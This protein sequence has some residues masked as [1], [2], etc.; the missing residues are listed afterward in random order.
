MIQPALAP[1]QI[2]ALSF[3]DGLSQSPSPDNPGLSYS[4]SSTESSSGDR[5]IQM[6]TFIDEPIPMY[7]AAQAPNATEF[8]PGS[9]IVNDSQDFRVSPLTCIKDNRSGK[10]LALSEHFG[11]HAPP[12]VVGADSLAVVNGYV[13]HASNPPWLL[14]GEHRSLALVSQ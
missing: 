2:Q 14:E 4:P 11:H 7:S 12:G 10:A 6:S 9:D 8:W 13:L 5:T 1:N 3:A